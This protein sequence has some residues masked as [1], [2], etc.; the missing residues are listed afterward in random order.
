MIDWPAILAGTDR[1]FLV[2][3][4]ST[5]SREYCRAVPLG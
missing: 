1:D 4:G 2:T 3:D 5:L